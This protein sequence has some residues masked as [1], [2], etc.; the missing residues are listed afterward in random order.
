M[1][2]KVNSRRFEYIHIPS[3]KDLLNQIP[4]IPFFYSKYSYTEAKVVPDEESLSGNEI[5]KTIFAKNKPKEPSITDQIRFYVKRFRTEWQRE[6]TLMKKEKLSSSRKTVSLFKVIINTFEGLFYL[7]VV[8][9]LIL[10][11]L[12]IVQPILV[13]FLVSIL[14]SNQN[15]GLLFSMLSAGGFALISFL[16]SSLLAKSLENCKT[17]GLF[18][19]AVLLEIMF[20][21]QLQHKDNIIRK[22]S[23]SSLLI[24]KEINLFLIDVE[25][26]NQAFYFIHFLWYTPILFFCLI[27]LF[28]FSL[29]FYLL[30]AGGFFLF[31]LF[32]EILYTCLL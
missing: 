1:E 29:N 25:K 23:S 14:Q 9:Q 26:C 6:V 27:A 17:L 16:S 10:L 4:Q 21:E 18:I 7:G 31:I 19:K 11:A 3:A 8:Y 28:Y 12:Q 22:Q 32:D 5:N 2:N 20:E 13:G 15:N 24:G 30:L